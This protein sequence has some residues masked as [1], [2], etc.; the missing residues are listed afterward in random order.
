M[1]HLVDRTMDNVIQIRLISK[2]DL[3]RNESVLKGL[4]EDNLRINFPVV[5]DLAQFIHSRY[6][7]MICF[8]HDG[9]AILIGAFKGMTI[10]G[11][12]W[13]YQKE[14]LGEQRLHIG[15]IVVDLDARLS[16]IGTRLL[17][18][19]ESIANEKSIKRIELMTT[20]ENSKAMN[21]YKSNDFAIVRVQLEKELE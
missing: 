1:V 19:L 15:Q 5:D 3:I 4:L 12:L 13:A 2:E 18:A 21:F 10:V 8:E 7:N 17:K 11:F 14:V 9:S 16:G 20:I 6:N